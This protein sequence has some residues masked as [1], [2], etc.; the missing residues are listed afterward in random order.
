MF[1]RTLNRSRKGFTI[2]ELVVVLAILV[3]L[4][5][6][7]VSQL[8]GIVDRSHSAT[9]A[10]TLA[11]IT[12]HLQTYRALHNGYPD[13][14]DTL[15]DATTGA[16]YAKVSPS[17]LAPAT[18]LNAPATLAPA[19]EQL[20]KAAGLNHVVTHDST[21]AFPSDSG[22]VSQHVVA[23]DG[24]SGGVKF[25]TINVGTTASPTDGR[26]LLG[27]AFGIGINNDTTADVNLYDFIVLGVGPKSWMVGQVLASAPVMGVEDA[28]RY[29]AR[30]LVVFAVPKSGTG[31]VKFLGTLASNGTTLNGSL[32]SY[33]S[34]QATSRDH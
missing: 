23:H 2:L 22:T 9:S 20:L 19:Q 31:S 1:V 6:L 24:S 3:V 17:L 8:D 32:A 18:L 26:N 4:A 28:G 5:G 15:V 14:N 25:V 27:G 33:Y 10:D 12:K 34:Q 7:V 21:V 13:G 16:L 29:Y 30:P 11:E